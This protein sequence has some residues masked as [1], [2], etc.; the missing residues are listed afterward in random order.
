MDKFVR[1]GVGG[2]MSGWGEGEGGGEI[3]AAKPPKLAV[4]FPITRTTEGYSNNIAL[5]VYS[6]LEPLVCVDSVQHGKTVVL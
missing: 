5:L 6:T 2:W 3:K 4:P 1:M